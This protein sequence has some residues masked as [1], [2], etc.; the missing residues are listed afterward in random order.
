LTTAAVELLPKQFLFVQ[1]M[2][3]RHLL[4]SG[5]FAAAKSRALCWKLRRS[6]GDGDL[7]LSQQVYRSCKGK[8]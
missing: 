3:T 6:D 2:H 7:V 4:Y 1:D 5:A 8:S